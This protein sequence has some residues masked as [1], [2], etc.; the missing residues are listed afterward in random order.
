MGDGTGRGGMNEIQR[1]TLA[2][3]WALNGREILT[4]LWIG[5][6]NVFLIPHERS[7][8]VRYKPENEKASVVKMKQM[9]GVEG[10]VMT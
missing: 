7:M 6:P 3:V 5:Q 9:R 10:G 1:V 8:G 4:E 2:D